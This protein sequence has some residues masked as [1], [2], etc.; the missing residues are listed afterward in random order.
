MVFF[1]SMVPGLGRIRVGIYYFSVIEDQLSCVIFKLWY[2]LV[3]W[4]LYGFAFKTEM[5]LVIA[6]KALLP[7]ETMN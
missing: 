5:S 4:T 2:V 6:L 7:T 1:I 3:Q